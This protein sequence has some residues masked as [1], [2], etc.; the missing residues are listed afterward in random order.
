MTNRYSPYYDRDEEVT[1]M[2]LDSGG[3]WVH[4]TMYDELATRLAE[5]ER[6]LVESSLRV[7]HD[8]SDLKERIDTFLR[9]T[10]SA[11]VCPVCYGMGVQ[12]MDDGEPRPCV[13]CNG[14][15]TVTVT[16]AP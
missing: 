3:S 5:A 4:V 7:A 10:V 9:P 13:K 14:R 12:K 8:A 1:R 11:T 6:L 2:D 15:R 16:G